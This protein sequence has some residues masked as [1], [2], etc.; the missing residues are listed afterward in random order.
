MSVPVSAAPTPAGKADLSKRVIAVII[1]AVPVMIVFIVLRW[2]PFIGAAVSGAIAAAWWL[3]RDGLDLDFADK[4]SPGKKI[5]KLR[6]IRLDGQAMDINTSAMRNFP[7]CIGSV[8]SIFLVIPLLGLIPAI[9]F[10]VVGLI[11]GI[12]EVFFV[13]TDAEGRRWG[14]KLAGTKV[15]EVAS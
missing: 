2:I 8:G 9:L 15:I 14:D 7:L 11:V 1:D 12:A 6:P 3:V 4:R 5:M 10:A 13:L